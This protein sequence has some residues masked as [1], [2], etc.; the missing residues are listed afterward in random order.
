MD[1]MDNT[2]GMLD[3]SSLSN[4]NYSN[5]HDLTTPPNPDSCPPIQQIE[6]EGITCPIVRTQIPETYFSFAPPLGTPAIYTHS[7]VPNSQLIGF[8]N[9]WLPEAKEAMA[10]IRRHYAKNPERACRF[11]TADVA[12]VLGRPFVL[13]V[14]PLA[15]GQMKK[16]ARGRVQMGVGICDELSTVV[17]NVVQLGS[18]DQRRGAFMSWANSVLVNNADGLCRQV[19]ERMGVDLGYDLTYKVRP[20]KD[21]IVTINEQAHIAW[22]SE[23]LNAYPAFCIAYAFACAIAKIVPP[24][25]DDIAEA[26]IWRQKLI[27]AGCPDAQ[28][29]RELLRDPD[30]PLARQ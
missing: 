12:Y 10:Q 6:F 13:Q 23:S 25:D 21:M 28:E 8:V 18:Y 22:L 26:T 30:S 24:P 19:L 27:E 14:K 1:T 17:L 2:H 7:A 5:D 15:Q 3:T 9:Q 4:N 11:E 29:A 16:A 20:L